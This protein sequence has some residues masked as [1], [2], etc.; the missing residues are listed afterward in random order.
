MR[1]TMER[2]R[3][4]VAIVAFL[5]RRSWGRLTLS[6]ALSGS[7][8]ARRCSLKWKARPGDNSRNG[9]VSLRNGSVSLKRVAQVAHLAK[10]QSSAIRIIQAETVIRWHRMGFRLYWRWMSRCCGG[11]PNIPGETRFLIR[12]MSLA[13]PLWGAPRIHGDLLKLGIEVSRSILA[14]YMVRSGRGR[15]QTWKTFL[16]DHAAG[17]AAMDFLVVPTVGFKMLFVLVIFRHQRRRLISLG[18][19]ANPTAEWIARQITEAFPWNEAPNYLSATATRPT[20]TLSPD[21]SQPW[22]SVI[23]QRFRG[24]SARTGM[25]RD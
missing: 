13:N 24:H 7:R 1:R 10:R 11:R 14:K 23:T 3:A 4:A 8:A 6:R 5:E 16:H 22:A 9:S 12:E 20:A 25:R 19:T 18:V 2:T 15:S 17:I 21:A